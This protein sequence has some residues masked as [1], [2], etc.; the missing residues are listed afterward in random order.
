[1]GTKKP[2]LTR[3]IGRDSKARN[4]RFKNV[5]GEMKRIESLLDILQAKGRL[6][7]LDQSF[8]AI[9]PKQYIVDNV[10]KF[11]DSQNAVRWP[12]LPHRLVVLPVVIDG[13]GHARG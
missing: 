5:M 13:L 11:L 9:L 3:T 7:L 4:I 8:G 10:G 1:M 12:V 2:F 6:E